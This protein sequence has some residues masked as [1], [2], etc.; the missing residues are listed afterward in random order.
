MVIYSTSSEAQLGSF[1]PYEIGDEEVVLTGLWLDHLDPSYRI[2][3]EIQ[4][5]WDKPIHADLGDLEIMI[6]RG[7]AAGEIVEWTQE[8]C[9]NSAFTNI[10]AST[11]EASPHQ[12][13]VLT[14][15]SSGTRARIIGPYRFKG[16]VLS[17]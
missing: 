2:V 13:Y 5:G 1:E 12:N 15:K 6:R 3:L 14:V 8:T 7:D 17:K 9:F 16:T 10:D 11:E 4:I